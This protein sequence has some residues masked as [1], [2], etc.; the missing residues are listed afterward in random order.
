MNLLKTFAA[1]S[2]IAL[3]SFGASAAPITSGGI[4][5]DPDYQHQ[6]QDFFAVSVNNETNTN[7]IVSGFG[8]IEKSKRFNRFLCIKY[9]LYS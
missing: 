9:F 1:A 8:Q 2:V 7:N 4:T 3:S 6:H 5:W